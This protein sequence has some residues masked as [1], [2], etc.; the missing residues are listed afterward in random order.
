M[1]P[2]PTNIIA[3]PAIKRPSVELVIVIA[4]KTRP[5]NPR[6]LANLPAQLGINRHIGQLICG[7]SVS[8]S[9][10]SFSVI[11]RFLPSL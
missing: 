1:R 11:F 2:T 5:I 7:V 9:L 10:V 6:K 8:F 4:P 3:R